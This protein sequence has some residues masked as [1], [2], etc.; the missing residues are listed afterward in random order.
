MDRYEAP[1]IWWAEPAAYIPSARDL[2]T[3]WRQ[4]LIP[5]S[6]IS[7]P[8]LLIPPS[9]IFSP[10]LHLFFSFKYKFSEKTISQRRKQIET[11]CGRKRKQTSKKP[12]TEILTLKWKGKWRAYRDYLGRR[13]DMPWVSQ[14]N[15][16][17]LTEKN[18]QPPGME[19]EAY[20]ATGI[21]N[22]E[23]GPQPAQK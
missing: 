23:R 4:L 11:T 22:K 20:T 1:N 12:Y 17:F 16:R 19:E 18:P 6:T 2:W 8:Q 5:S 10:E 21:W 14:W 3:K 7:S 15:K 9:T 13:T